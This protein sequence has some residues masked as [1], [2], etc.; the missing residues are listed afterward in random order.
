[1]SDAAS[2]LM[3]SLLHLTLRFFKVKVVKLSDDL[4]TSNA[5]VIISQNFPCCF[6]I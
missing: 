4:D 6:A 5:L 1:M 3:L 2:G